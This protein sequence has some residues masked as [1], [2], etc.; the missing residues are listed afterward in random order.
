MFL[1]SQLILENFESQQQAEHGG[2]KVLG[3]GNP[4]NQGV[5]VAGACAT[6][7]SVL[8]TVC[9]EHCKF[10]ICETR[11]VINTLVGS[12]ITCGACREMATPAVARRWFAHDSRV[13]AFAQ[14]ATRRFTAVRHIHHNSYRSVSRQYCLR[15]A[16]NG[17]APTPDAILVLGGGLHE[18]GAVPA[19]GE[20]RIRLA[21]DLWHKHDCAPKILLLGAGTPHKPAVVKDNGAVLH[22]AAAYADVLLAEGVPADA[23]LKE[24]SVRGVSGFGCGAGA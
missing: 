19:W 16:S 1:G 14:P 18:G 20:R 9:L 5:Q 24:C 13:G 12:R 10:S 15:P 11:V 21:A 8:E 23:L 22:E 2:F 6:L 3:N 17:A 4:G 7:A